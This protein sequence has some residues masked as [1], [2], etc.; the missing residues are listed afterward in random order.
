MAETASVVREDKRDLEMTRNHSTRV[1]ITASI[2]AKRS[3]AFS[4]LD[5]SNVLEILSFF[6]PLALRFCL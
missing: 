5:R 6:L 3:R 4:R 2:T 1:A